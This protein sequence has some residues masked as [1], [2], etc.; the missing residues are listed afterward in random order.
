MSKLL[1]VTFWSQ[2]VELKQTLF[3]KSVL[4]MLSK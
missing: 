1:V 2:K 3:A 4:H